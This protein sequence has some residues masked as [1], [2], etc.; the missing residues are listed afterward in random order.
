VVR[1]TVTVAPDSPATRF[2][3]DRGP[4]ATVEVRFG[5][6]WRQVSSGVAATAGSRSTWAFDVRWTRGLW[7][8]RFSWAAWGDPEVWPVES[9]WMEVN[10]K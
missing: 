7:R 10:A 5:N 2:V 4:T 3:P 8:I 6:E 1:Y 9:P